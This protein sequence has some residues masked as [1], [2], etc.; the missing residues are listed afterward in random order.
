MFNLS[1]YRTHFNYINLLIRTV[2]GCRFSCVQ[3]EITRKLTFPK[4]PTNPFLEMVKFLLER[5]APVHIDSE[6]IRSEKECQPQDKTDV[7]AGYNDVKNASWVL[8]V[9]PPKG[10]L[11]IR[12]E[13]SVLD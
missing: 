5:I 11:L 12:F 4:Q 2:D 8:F 7:N 10:M 13:S 6:A 9:V 3:R 1:E